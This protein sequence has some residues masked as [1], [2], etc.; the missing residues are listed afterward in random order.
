MT[1]LMRPLWGLLLLVAMLLPSHSAFAQKSPA[2]PPPKT[3]PAKST[4]KPLEATIT[5]T[6]Y[7]PP[8]MYGQW[9]VTARLVAPTIA[10]VALL[11]MVYL[12]ATHYATILNVPP[13]TPEAW[14]WPASF[15]VIATLG[16]LRG[17]YLKAQRPR[18]YDAMVHHQSPTGASQ[19]IQ[20][21]GAFR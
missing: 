15:A 6:N 5:A 19:N 11:A 20:R 12:V 21:E 1:A 13:G 18:V 9:S 16:L 10:A 14:Q 17:W 7:L 4:A 8:E 2:P 3:A